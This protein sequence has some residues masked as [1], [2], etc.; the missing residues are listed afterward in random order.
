[1]SETI[2]FKGIEVGRCSTGTTLI[3]E[4]CKRKNLDIPHWLYPHTKDWPRIAFACD[5]FYNS[6]IHV[7]DF[8]FD[9]KI[10]SEKFSERVFYVV[11]ELKGKWCWRY[12]NIGNDG[13]DLYFFVFEL[14][15]E[16]MAFKIRWS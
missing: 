6:N 15:E 7:Y 16:A 8:S 11:D 10:Q 2:T 5:S 9:F 3:L 12:V 13:R 1:M 4:Y 14:E